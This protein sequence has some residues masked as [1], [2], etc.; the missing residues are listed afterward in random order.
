MQN[1]GE[2]AGFSGADD[3]KCTRGAS[4]REQ[5]KRLSGK[6]PLFRFEQQRKTLRPVYF[7]HTRSNRAG[8]FFTQKVQRYTV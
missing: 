1:I 3:V 8:Y 4:G 2:A 6:F 7:L 5:T